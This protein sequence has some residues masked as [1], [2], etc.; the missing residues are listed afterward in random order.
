MSLLS[1]AFSGL[2]DENHRSWRLERFQPLDVMKTK[3]LIPIP[4]GGNT[5]CLLIIW[6]FALILGPRFALAQGSSPPLLTTITNP[7]PV[8]GGGFGASVTAVGSDRVLIGANNAA[9]A[10][11]F[12]VNGTLLTTITNPMPA[13]SDNFGIAVA[14]VGSDRVIIG[15]EPYTTAPG[16]AYLFALAYPPLSIA[17]NAGTVSDSWITLETGL[18]LQQTDLLGVP[19]VWN[20]TTNLVS[21]T[22]VT[23]VV[24]QTVGITNRFFRLGRP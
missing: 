24:Q 10:Y 2:W 14:A 3:L 5:A 11:L 9:R 17:R 19:T 22:G 13:S 12:N 23:N 15:R 20:D 18:I 21:V 7:A 1:P 6:L 4:H 8:A 16:S